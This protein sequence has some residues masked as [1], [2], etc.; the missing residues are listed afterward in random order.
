MKYARETRPLERWSYT[1]YFVGQ[2]IV[3]SLIQGYL[4]IFSTSY[5]NIRPAIVATVF[6]VVR[7]WD[8]V[9]DPMIGLLMDRFRFRK[10]R[11]KGWLSITAFLMPISTFALF[12]TPPASPMAVKIG[13]MVVTYLLWDVFYTASEVPSFAVST[14]MANTER[15]RTLLLTLTQIGSVAG[16]A[17]GMG[18]AFIF[19]GDGIDEINWV[20]F[21]GTPALIALV[22]MVPQIWTVQE[23]H[24][25][26]QRND[27]SIPEMVRQLLRNDQHF[28]MMLLFT[29]QAFLNAAGVFAPF[30]AEYIYGSAQ[31]AAATGLFSLIGIMGLGALTPAIVVRYGK[32]RY[33]ETSMLL[34][35]VLSIPVF[36]IPG[37]MAI[38]AMTF[39]G[40]RTIALVVTSLLR[41]MFTADCVEYGQ[42]KTGVRSDSAAFAV[43]TFFNKTGDAIG[44][45]LGG[46]FLAVAAYD[47][48]LRLAQQSAGTMQFL[49]VAYIVLPMVMAAVMYLGP[50]LFYKIDEQQVI[51]YIKKNEAA[52]RVPP[53]ASA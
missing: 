29:S 6:L 38:L 44:T 11:F 7:I 46:Y 3:Y 48:T 34:C 18:L 23:R 50:K 47:E 37:E 25:P 8:A 27:V 9:N 26:E 36:F 1:L 41:P 42:Q 16:A 51:E 33:L 20:L 22:I 19:L 45:A 12:L 14:A 15:E 53:P 39:L 10:Y 30:V 40:L 52:A 32:R 17:L 43:Q 13:L 21:A 24:N 5:L 4:L 2:N 49:W 31:L 35:I 28:I